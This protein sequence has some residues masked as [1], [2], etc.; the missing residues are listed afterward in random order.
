MTQFCPYPSPLSVKF[1]TFFW[2]R[3]SLSESSHCFPPFTFAS[4]LIIMQSRGLQIV[5]MLKSGGALLVSTIMICQLWRL[6]PSWTTPSWLVTSLRSSTT[7]RTMSTLLWTWSTAETDTQGN[8]ILHLL[9]RKGDTNIETI[10]SLLNWW[11]STA[12]VRMLPNLTNCFNVTDSDGKNGI[13][14]TEMA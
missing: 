9:A 4:M 12:L 14:A 3:P 13:W 11:V 7:S 8:S 10:K 6:R 2:V 5:R 1:H